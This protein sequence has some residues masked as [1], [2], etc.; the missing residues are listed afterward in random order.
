MNDEFKRFIE[1]VKGKLNIV[2][3]AASYLSLERR[4]GN[5]WA[6]CP[7]HHEKTPSFSINTADQYYHCFGCGESGDVI[8]LVQNLE[9]VE[10][11]DAVKN[12]A[13]R[14]NLEV[15]K[16]SG[17]D[18][19][20]KTVETKRKKDAILKILNEAAHFYLNNLNSEKAA[21]HV[22]YI[23]KRQIPSTLVRKFGLGASLNYSDLPAYLLDKGYQKQDIIDSGAVNFVN[24]RL[25]DAQGER[26]IYPIINAMNE[27]VAF[28]GRALKK[29]EFGKYKNTRETLVFTKSKMLYNINLL[30]KLKRE[31]TIKS[32]IMVEGYMDVIS[33]YGAGFKNVVASMG[34][35]LTQE[36]ARILKRYTDD[37]LISYDGDAAGQ[38]ANMRGLEILKSEGLNVRVVPLP[39]GLDPDDVIK[40]DGKEGY[41]ACLNNALPLIDFKL[42]SLLSGSD[43]SKSDEKRK[44]VSSALE[45]VRSASSAAEQEELLKWLREKT[46]IS[47]ESL[48]RDL[49]AVPE[50]LTPV[51]AEPQKRRDSS[52]VGDKASRFVIA[53]LLFGAK[54]ADGVDIDAIPF[55][56][57]VHKIIAG[58]VKSKRLF[59]ERVQPS[60]V[61]EFFEENT[62]EYTELTY[63]LDLNDGVALEGDVAEKYFVDCVKT[64][65]LGEVDRRIG[66]IRAKIDGEVDASARTTLCQVLNMLLVEKNKIKNM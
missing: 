50:I 30:K 24:G 48:K 41:A 57:E 5:F 11:L 56:N 66:A 46:G 18:D 15:P 8:K 63:V 36:Q 17:A 21:A 31:E 62:P 60:E 45:V 10:F 44:F 34:T 51:A 37:V 42:H 23:L 47:F 16:S 7:F 4:G 2:D 64:L 6:C 29:V 25:T 35:S 20:E 12:L 54:F 3:V 13:A 59:D 9:N 38:N 43:L 26:L 19:S 27:V 1:V 52:P 49:N 28:G 58:Y 53:A 61:F 55:S 39:D 33:L 14:L 22:D 32:V 65:R 40:R